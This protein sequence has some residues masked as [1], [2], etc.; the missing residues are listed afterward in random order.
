MAYE[1]G[2]QIV[3]D[4]LNQTAVV[5]FRDKISFHGPFENS[6]DAY[7]AG[8]DHCR[9]MGWLDLPIPPLADIV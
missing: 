1:E 3:F 9:L 2:M 6:R 7:A 4:M 5:V 8:E